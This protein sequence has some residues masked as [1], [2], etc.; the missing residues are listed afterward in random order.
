MWAC[1]AKNCRGVMNGK[2]QASARQL[3]VNLSE[4]WTSPGKLH[5][6]QPLQVVNLSEGCILC[7]FGF[8]LN[9]RKT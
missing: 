7:A 5:R 2:L 3:V 6:A 9:L 1:P 8:F 4:G